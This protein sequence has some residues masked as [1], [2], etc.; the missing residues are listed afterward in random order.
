MLWLPWI[1]Q[2]SAPW[3]HLA[4]RSKQNLWVSAGIGVQ[5]DS[6]CHRKWDPSGRVCV[7]EKG[8]SHL[9]MLYSHLSPLSRWYF[10][11]S[12]ILLTVVTLPLELRAGHVV[13]GEASVFACWV[14]ARCSTEEALQQQHKPH[15]TLLLISLCH[16]SHWRGA[17]YVISVKIDR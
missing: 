5:T 10:L 11:S 9:R 2:F 15:M 17:R 4:A 16:T 8:Q 14:P 7:R 3:W 1:P 12:F 6:H 13:M